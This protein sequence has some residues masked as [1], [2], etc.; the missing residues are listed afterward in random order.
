[1]AKLITIRKS[2]CSFLTLATI[3]IGSAHADVLSVFEINADDATGIQATVDAFR[4]ALG[5]LNAPAPVNGDPNGRRQI[6]WDAAPDDFSDPNPFPGNFFN[7]GSAP[8]ARGIEFVEAGDTSGF[9]LSSTEASGQPVEFGAPDE[10]TFFSSERLFTPVNDSL[11]DVYFF[12]PADQVTRAY[13]RGLGVVFTDVEL[14]DETYMNFY[15][16]N[17]NLLYSRSVLTGNN[18]SLS[19]LGVIFDSLEVARVRIN[20]GVDGS[21]NVAMDDFIFGEPV[22]MAEVS[23]PAS[24][25]FMLVGALTLTGLRRRKQN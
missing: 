11:F 21:D 25:L 9:L 12:D 7:F 2:V 18:A 19:F 20:A 6:N 13:T 3:S 22:A 1:M 10:Y 17:D 24:A 15:D 16:M 5:P 14:P 23:A 4:D 8:R